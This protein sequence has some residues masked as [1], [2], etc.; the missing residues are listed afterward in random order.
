MATARKAAVDP[1]V[2]E[3]PPAP[4]PKPGTAA[5]VKFE[6]QITPYVVSGTTFYRWEILDHNHKGYVGD[7]AGHRD[8]GF[9]IPEDAEADAALYVD[10]VRQAVTLKLNAPDSYRI[11]L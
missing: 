1:L 10:R 9:R 11:T 4:E 5:E 8:S 6:I 7:Y 2:E 3:L